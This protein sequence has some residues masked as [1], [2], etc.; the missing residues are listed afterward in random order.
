MIQKIMI[1]LCLIIIA[2]L[3][4]L[5]K[6]TPS[7]SKGTIIEDPEKYYHLLEK[8]IK[9]I[10]K[11]TD[12]VPD[13]AIVLGSGLG[14]FADNI[15]VVAEVPY[16]K[17]S[18]FP[19]ATNKDHEGKFIFGKIGN[20]K[21]VCSKGRIHYYEGYSMQQ[22]TTPMRLMYMLGAKTVIL[23]NAAGAINDNY[24]VGD[25]VSCYDFITNNVPSPVAGDISEKFGKRF[26]DM[27]YIC[28]KK[29]IDDLHKVAEKNNILLHDGIYVQTAGPQFETPTEIKSYRDMGADVVGMSTACE[30][31]VARQMNMNI[32]CISFVSNM[33]AGITG[34]ALSG[35]EVNLSA[36]KYSE[37]FKTLLVEL[38]KAL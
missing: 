12:F 18:D 21:V 27:T 7:K 24:K 30:A 36:E 23:T 6:K 13:V 31:I 17:L 37:S 29:I 20:V 28:D 3:I 15:D 33:A 8:N 38:L 34:T 9:Q 32:C 16:G 35:E 14:N 5:I 22:V 4:Y 26:F 19:V 10:R 2:L 1:V 11:I 25:F